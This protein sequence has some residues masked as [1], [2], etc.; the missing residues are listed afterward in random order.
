MKTPSLFVF[1]SLLSA[2]AAF[3]QRV[4]KQK[5]K[6]VTPMARKEDAL[7]K[8]RLVVLPFLDDSS[9]RPQSI[10]DQARDEFILLLNKTQQLVVVDSKDLDP[11][12]INS[13]NDFNM[14]ELAKEA[15]KLGASAVLEGKILDI[16]VKNASDEVG[17]FRTLKTKFEC[18]VRVRIFAARTGKELYNV[19][20]TV[21]VEESN[22]RVAESTDTDRFLKSNPK[23][24]ANLIT[25]SFI[26]FNPAIVDTMAKLNW[27][28]R[29]AVING[30]RVYLNVGRISGLN[31]GDILRVS[32]EG[33][34]V[35]DPQTGSYIGKVTGRTKGTLEVVS[36]F[37]QDGA[38]AVVHSGAGFKEN[39]RVEL[40]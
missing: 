35:F 2:C 20:K 34:E 8:Q 17:V 26:D 16:K 3:D 38:I 1:L 21:T 12:N 30:D 32:D 14:T 29:I 25:E 9:E 28:G 39:D 40:Y 7:P 5:I 23:I 19:T 37:G 36:Y 11:K 4:E 31:I 18:K 15:A 33:E 13:K 6:D 10:R 24:I 22:V 27:E